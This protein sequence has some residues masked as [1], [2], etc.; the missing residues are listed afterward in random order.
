MRSPLAVF[1]MVL[2]SVAL[3]GCAGMGTVCSAVGYSSVAT[4]TLSEP[5]VG[6]SLELC[7]GED[8]EP[9]LPPQGDVQ[10]AETS[11]VPFVDTGVVR[12]DGDSARGWNATFVGGQPVVEYR[13]RDAAGE[14]ISEDS[15]EVDWVRVGGTARCG[16][17]R[18]AVIEI[19]N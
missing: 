8:C 4:I 16:G 17:P 9:G 1:T 2:M 7:D 19:P 13:L 6:V 12:L 18:E 14:V 5:R 11:P 3:A 15:I 10:P